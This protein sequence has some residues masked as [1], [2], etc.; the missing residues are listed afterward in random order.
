[1]TKLNQ[2]SEEYSR[3]NNPWIGEGGASRAVERCAEDLGQ[4]QGVWC[5]RRGNTETGQTDSEAGVSLEGQQA[6][7]SAARLA[8]WK[9]YGGTWWWAQAKGPWPLLPEVQAGVG[10]NLWC[11][12]G[13]WAGGLHF[14]GPNICKL[15]SWGRKACIQMAKQPK[16]TVN[17]QPQVPFW[18]HGPAGVGTC[19]GNRSK[20]VCLF[21][22]S[23]LLILM[24]AFYCEHLIVL[25]KF[26]HTL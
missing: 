13:P 16:F 23:F 8:H 7:F 12:P 22:N 3:K 26:P 24:D 9:C 15:T 2:F 20:A 17:A 18:A 11:G 6:L 14:E 19:C 1:M 4:E 10:S 21:W 25:V 5:S